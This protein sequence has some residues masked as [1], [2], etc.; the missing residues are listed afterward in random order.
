MSPV[1][2]NTECQAEH[3]GQGP[4][5]GA[6]AVSAAVSFTIPTPPSVNQLF[7]NLKGKGRVKTGVYNDWIGF[8]LTAIRLQNVQPVAGRVLVIVGVERMSLSSD[9]DNRLKACLD[10]IVK[11]EIIEDDSL[12]TAIAISWLPKS[13]GL[14]HLHLLP[15]GPVSI[16]FHPSPDRATGGWFLPSPSTSGEDLGYQDF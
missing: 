11:A 16:D 4:A 13:N 2:T 15:A 6:V 9:I 12:I 8:A 1:S 14:T 7:R 5:A 3:S 10:A